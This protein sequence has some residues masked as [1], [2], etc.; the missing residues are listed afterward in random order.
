MDDIGRVDPRFLKIGAS[1]SPWGLLLVS[2][3]V[4]CGIVM[5]S[6]DTSSSSSDTE[7]VGAASH[8][9]LCMQ[10]TIQTDPPRGTVL[11]Q[12]NNLGVA[13]VDWSIEAGDVFLI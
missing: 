9:Y 6:T 7:M 5:F 3:V 12:N 13:P 11:I 1:G 4:I 10:V 2:L 8:G